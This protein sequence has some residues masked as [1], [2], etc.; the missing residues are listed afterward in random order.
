[1]NA[2]AAR[3]AD[4]MHAGAGYIVIVLAV[5]GLVAVIVAQIWLARTFKRR[6]NVGML[7]SA[8]VLLLI[9]IGSLV[10]VLQLR[11]ALN[12]ISHRKPGRGQH[13]R[14]HP[15]RGEQRQVEREPNADRPRIG[16]VV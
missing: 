13:C 10:A 14:R 1:M 16:T 5:L 3:A 2:N 15:D 12:D 8:V 11:G 6:I 4:E 7:A 9:V